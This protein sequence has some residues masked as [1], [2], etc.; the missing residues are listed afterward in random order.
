M[1]ESGEG[2]PT[3]RFV[4]V[5]KVDC[6]GDMSD[7]NESRIMESMLCASDLGKDACSGDSGGK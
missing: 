6:L 5:K 2:S 3:L 7:Y 1:I 4:K